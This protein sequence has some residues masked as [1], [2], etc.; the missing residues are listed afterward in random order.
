VAALA[1]CGGG[2]VPA[3]PLPTPTPTPGPES[4]SVS[5]TINGRIISGAGTSDIALELSFLTT[6]RGW[7][8]S[9]MSAS[10]S[11]DLSGRNI[12]LTLKGEGAS[13]EISD[14]DY[15]ELVNEL[16]SINLNGATIQISLSPGL[17]KVASYTVTTIDESFTN[18]LGGINAG[19]LSKTGTDVSIAFSTLSSEGTTMA[20]SNAAFVSSTSISSVSIPGDAASELSFGFAARLKHA[21]T[22]A[23][24]NV[25]NMSISTAR[26]PM[27]KGEDM[28][29]D[30]TK[31]LNHS[32]N[33]GKVFAE[34][35][36][37]ST[38]LPGFKVASDGGKLY[39]NNEGNASSVKVGD[40]KFRAPFSANVV[41][42]K[43]FMLQTAYN[44]LQNTPSINI[45]NARGSIVP[46]TPDD[47]TTAFTMLGIDWT[48]SNSYIPFSMTN[49][50]LE[51]GYEIGVPEGVNLKQYPQVTAFIGKNL[52]G[53]SNSNTLGVSNLMGAFYY[54]NSTVPYTG[55]GVSDSGEHAEAMNGDLAKWML[56]NGINMSQVKVGNPSSATNETFSGLT[57]NLVFEG[58]NWKNNLIGVSGVTTFKGDL[59][60]ISNNGNLWLVVNGNVGNVKSA[61]NY[62]VLEFGSLASNI[63]NF[64]SDNTL[65]NIRVVSKSQFQDLHNT[66]QG[67]NRNAVWI[68]NKLVPTTYS[69]PSIKSL[70]TSN[71]FIRKDLFAGAVK[72]GTPFSG[73]AQGYYTDESSDD[74]P[75]WGNSDPIP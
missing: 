48:S 36:V 25:T 56:K 55:N 28:I 6:D 7:D 15:D 68:N 47:L 70:D 61:S 41:K 22:A 8:L 10:V 49:I 14:T 62:K 33:A 72:N 11:G 69:D 23:G 74:I 64:H 29:T 53:I 52:A 66:I 21:L 58:N 44:K 54:A 51:G 19:I 67:T 43:G 20:F 24:A 46:I 27:F 17:T 5:I 31:A 57:Q 2:S 34:F 13:N 65:K 3:G 63:N 73:P 1:S 16:S 59:A 45:S 38:V 12:V 32:D 35:G 4:V 37:G 50:S 18:I 60:T 40:L 9:S 71:M 75:K 30:D 42:T 26:T 39:L